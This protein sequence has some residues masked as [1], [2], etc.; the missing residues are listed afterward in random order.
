MNVADH[1]YTDIGSDSLYI[2]TTYETFTDPNILNK[3]ASTKTT[4]DSA[5]TNILKE[6]V[7]DY[8]DTTGNVVESKE[9]LD[10]ANDYIE[11]TTFEYDQYG[12][13]TKVTDPEGYVTETEYDDDYAIYPVD[14]NTAGFV[15]TAVYDANSGLPLE[16]TDVMGIATKNVYDN[17]YRLTDVYVS[18]E[19]EGDPNLWLTHIEY[20][21]EGITSGITENYVYQIHEGYEAYTYNDGLGRVVQTRVLAEP[22]APN[23]CRVS[24]VFY[25]PRG[26]VY[27]ESLPYFSDAN[28]FTIWDDNT[29]G[30]LTEFDA[31]GRAYKITPPTGDVNSPTGPST[32]EFRD[33]NDLW[34]TVSTDAEGNKKKQYMNAQ[35]RVTKL[36]EVITGGN[37]IETRYEYDDIGRLIKTYDDANNVIELSYDSL[38]RKTDSN[39]PDMGYWTY[40]YDDLG[41]LTEQE[42]A[43]GN[44]VEIIYDPNINRVSQRKIYDVNDT[45]VET[46][47]YTYD[48]GETGYTVY[49]GL[50][51]KVEDGEGWQ[52]FGHDSRGRVIKSTRYV[53]AKSKAYTTQTSYDDADRV[54]E[55]V[56]P[57]NR[58]TIEY[59]YDDVGHLIKVESTSGVPDSNEVFYEPEGYNVYGQLTGVDFGNGVESRYEFYTYSKRL[60]R[61][62]TYTD[63]ND[64]NT[65]LQDLTYTFDKLSNIKSITDDVYSGS[66]NGTLS[67]IVYD[68]LY[69]LKS[70]YCG[71]ADANMTYSYNTLGNIT[72]NS[73]GAGSS[74]TYGGS[75]PHT[76]TSAYGKSYSYDACGN[77]TA[78]GSDTLTYDA[79]NRLIKVVKDSNDIE[80]GYSADGTRLYKKFNSTVTQVWI[81]DIYEEK[82]DKILCHVYAGDKLVA[83]FEPASS[84]SRF[85]DRNPLLK[86]SYEYASLTFTGLFGGGRIPLTLLGFGLLAGIYYGLRYRK[87]THGGYSFFY[88][89]PY[90]QL[91][92]FIIIVSVFVAST[93]GICY[94]GTPTYDPVFYYYHSD[95]LGSSNIMTNRDGEQV[96]HYGYMPFGNERYQDNTQAFSVTNRYTGQ[97]LDEETGLYFYGSRYYDP[98]LAR[99]IQPD[100]IVPDASSQGLNRYTYANNNPLVFV[101]PSG[102]VPTYPPGY[103]PYPPSGNNFLSHT[104][105]TV[106]RWINNFLCNVGTAVGNVTRG[107]LGAVVTGSDPAAVAANLLGGQ[108]EIVS[109]NPLIAADP[110]YDLVTELLK[111]KERGG[112]FCGMCHSGE[113]DHVLPP[114]II[115]IGNRIPPKVRIGIIALSISLIVVLAAPAVYG[116][117]AGG[118]VALTS[119]GLLVA[120]SNGLGTL[121][122]SQAALGTAS[123]STAGGGITVYRAMDAAGRV[124]YVGITNSIVRRGGEQ[125]RNLGI[126]IQAIPGLKNLNRIQA[127]GVE[128][129]LINLHGLEKNGGTLLNKINSIATQNPVY[130][131]M[132]QYGNEMLKNV[133]YPGAGG[134]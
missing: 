66:A 90:R 120:G 95:H 62:K 35:G 10:D 34:V 40:Q 68:D 47:T 73:E 107:T 126:R 109:G 67:N 58:A 79:R 122:A 12:N 1:T 14:V 96:Q 7:F 99:F 106:R 115:P 89:S 119:E 133:N 17:F 129:A 74:Y 53:T 80:F 26:N 71:G 46:I 111:Y 100:S 11:S 121:A 101:D 92:G 76:V 44:V 123:I 124:I 117:V 132:V 31:L 48:S 25:D 4:T 19:P 37:D 77:M 5:G 2:H 56:Y 86:K 29:D 36:V 60:K 87:D 23:D 70:L 78:R 108:F 131:S 24:D 61:I 38:G 127:R 39:D 82:D 33:G 65:Y 112:R 15:T 88:K 118:S 42:D 13:R 128:Q 43:R 50:L 30:V 22:A 125:L 69:R 134:G 102:H 98:E 28:D 21:M 6:I 59:S 116:Y 105:H 51:F 3:I 27:F 32:T 49:K 93:P 18:Q 81:G 54:T 113:L 84:L 64:P 104:I 16:Q 114:D 63:A 72:Y 41:R 45:L 130:E 75:R 52:K 55:I 85:I 9:W 103:N 57:D 8:N 91:F 83:T 97:H 110:G 94:A 20:S